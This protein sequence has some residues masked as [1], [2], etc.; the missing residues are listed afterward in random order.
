MSKLF[1]FLYHIYFDH[2]QETK[3][4]VQVDEL[5]ERTVRIVQ[6]RCA[7]RNQHNFLFLVCYC[8][9]TCFLAIDVASFSAYTL[10]RDVFFYFV[11]CLFVSIVLPV[12]V[13]KVV[14]KIAICAPSHSCRA[15]S[16]QLRH[17][18]AIVKTC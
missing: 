10:L 11:L 1:R 18:S 9:D 8:F 13:N 3:I 17:A 7:R 12:E 2:E 16:L 14:Q 4:P 15:M 6:C 5:A